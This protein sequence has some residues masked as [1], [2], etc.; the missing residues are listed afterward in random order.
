MERADIATRFKS[1]KSHPHWNGGKFITHNGYILTKCPGHP[2]ANIHGYVFEHILVCEKALGKYLPKGTEPHH[3]NGN[4]SDN[5]PD[6]LILCQDR[7]Y[8]MMIHQRQRS[9]KNCHHASWRK[10]WI[11]KQY[12]DPANLYIAQRGKPVY[13]RSCGNRYYNELYLRRKQNV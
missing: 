11:C 6:N 1:G 10:C 4:K 12:D 3:I 8:H 2:K 7:A 5:R 9:L 13:H